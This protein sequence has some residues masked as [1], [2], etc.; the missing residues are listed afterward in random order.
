M[1]QD[2]PNVGEFSRKKGHLCPCF[3]SPEEG[4][5]QYDVGDSYFCFKGLTNRWAKDYA[6]R[7]YAL[8]NQFCADPKDE[9]KRM[10]EAHAREITRGSTFVPIQLARYVNAVKQTQ[11]DEMWLSIYKWLETNMIDEI[12]HR[13]LGNFKTHADWIECEKQLLAK[14]T[15]HDWAVIDGITPRR[16]HLLH[17]RT[18]TIEM[19]HRTDLLFIANRPKWEPARRSNATQKVE[20]LGREQKERRDID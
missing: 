1:S 13:M 10:K 8:L 5:F 9:V 11:S 15:P 14:Y 19:I 20:S 6:Y 7:Y 3:K 17:S 2:T 4:P 12:D 18:N 16:W